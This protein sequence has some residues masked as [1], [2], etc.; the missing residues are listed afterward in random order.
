MLPAG[1]PAWKYPILRALQK[2]GAYVGD[3]G[4]YS[5]SISFGIQLESGQHYVKS[6]EGDRLG[7]W[8]NAHKAEG[9]ISTGA[10]GTPYYLLDFARGVDWSRL[11]VVSP[12]V[13]DGSC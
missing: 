2:Y 6:G 3:T 12:C 10:N 4:A 1:L 8:A 11:R 9:D 13:A 5:R 7:Q